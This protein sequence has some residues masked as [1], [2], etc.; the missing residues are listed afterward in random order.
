MQVSI[1]NTLWPKGLDFK[2]EHNLADHDLACLQSRL[3]PQRL[4]RLR[5]IVKLRS[6]QVMPILDGVS[7][8]GNTNAVMR[9]AELY[10]FLNF[11]IVG[12]AQKNNKKPNRVNKGALRW[13]KLSVFE[14]PEQA[15]EFLKLRGYRIYV[16]DVMASKTLEECDL[17]T[18]VALVFGNEHRGA[19]QAMLDLGCDAFKLEVRGL[20][21]SFNVSVAAAISFE[22]CMRQ[23]KALGLTLADLSPLEQDWLLGSYI[24]EQTGV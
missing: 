5:S 8:P 22:K 1:A 7:D 20:C 3:T 14:A 21:Q 17:S 10:G 16:A 9:T 11:G 2:T 23:K 18:P 24:R 4:Q 15:V 13:L 19:S 6:K 12:R